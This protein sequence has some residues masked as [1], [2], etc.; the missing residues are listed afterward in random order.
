MISCSDCNKTVEQQQWKKNKNSQDKF[1]ER[2]LKVTA[3]DTWCKVSKR[4]LCA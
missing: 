4:T 1:K 2:K 3:V